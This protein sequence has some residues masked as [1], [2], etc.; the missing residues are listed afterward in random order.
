[1]SQVLPKIWTIWFRFYHIYPSATGP[2]LLMYRSGQ[3]FKW[4]VHN[5]YCMNNIWVEIEIFKHGY[6]RQPWMYLGLCSI[7]S[8]WTIWFALS[9]CVK[10]AHIKCYK[11]Q[12]AIPRI[13]IWFSVCS[14]KYNRLIKN[15]VFYIWFILRFGLYLPR[16]VLHF[17]YISLLAMAI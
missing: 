11:I 7:S 2:S 14:H 5:T 12:D 9:I 6:V 10:F 16:D 3:S 8:I 15:F 17:L 13:Y 4:S 1:M